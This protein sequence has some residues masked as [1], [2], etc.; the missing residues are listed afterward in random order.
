MSRE[1]IYEAADELD[2]AMEELKRN[3]KQVG[4]E[5]LSRILV[6][7]EVLLYGDSKL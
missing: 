4:A 7:V 3:F 2:R 5:I 1:S 6:A